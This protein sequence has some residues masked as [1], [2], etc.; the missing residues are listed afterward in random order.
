MFLF[1]IIAAVDKHLH[2]LLEICQATQNLQLQDLS[3]NDSTISPIFRAL[4]YQNTLQS[5]C[6]TGNLLGDEG[7]K[8]NTTYFF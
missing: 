8:V 2:N 1:F 3:L 4:R 6:L 5:I 7:L